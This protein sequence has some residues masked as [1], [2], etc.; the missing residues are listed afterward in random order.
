MEQRYS[1]P[2]LELYGLYRALRAF[3]LYLIGVK[4]LIVEV[5]AKYI[6]G[7]LNAPDLQPNTAM[8]RW[9]QG[10][11]LFD[12][13]LKH[14]SG[15]SH[16]AADALSRRVLGEEEEV[17]EHDDSWLDDIA[18][19]AGVMESPTSVF[20]RCEDVQAQIHY[21]AEDLPSSSF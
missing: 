7:M 15:R 21:P 19:Y 12:F 16:Q 9:I 6:K 11:M 4:N 18:L 20:S 3:R 13:A 2:K 10:I 1:Q 8:N 14:I 17:E 5:D